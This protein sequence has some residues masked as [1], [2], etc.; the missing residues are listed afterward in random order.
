M[1][2]GL[3]GGYIAP[4]NIDGEIYH[5]DALLDVKRYNDLIN[6]IERDRFLLI[7]KTGKQYDIYLAQFKMQNKYFPFRK[8]CYVLARDYWQALRLLQIELAKNTEYYS[9]CFLKNLNEGER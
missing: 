4:P 5:C 7:Q 6:R 9:V 2:R 1:C 3:A 8:A